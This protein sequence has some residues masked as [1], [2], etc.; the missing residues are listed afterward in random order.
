MTRVKGSKLPPGALDG[1]RVIDMTS[2]LFGPYCTQ[3]LGDMG[4]DVIKVEGLVGDSTRKTGPSRNPGMASVFLGNNRN[5]RSIAVDAKT[6]EGRDVIL[7]LMRE[8]HVFVTNVRPL[9]V[10]RLGLG[11]N[12]AC[13]ENPRLVYCNAVGYSQAGVYA[14]LPAFDDTIQAMCGTAA[15]QAELTGEP[16]YVGSAIADKVSGLMLA[17]AIV[18]AVRHAERTGEGQEVEVPMFE[19]MVS[20]N[21]VEHLYGSTFEP[22]MGEARYPRIISRFRRPYKTLDGYIAVIPYNDAHWKKFFAL[23]G[24]PEL[25]REPR[26]ATMG[27]RTSN[28]DALYEMLAGHIATRTSADWLERLQSADIPAAPVRSL[29]ELVAN[30]Q[31]LKETGFFRHVEHPTEG[32]ILHTA[33]PVRMGAS[34]L[35]LRRHAPKLGE[36][37]A[38]ILRELG[39]SERDIEHLRSIGA[40]A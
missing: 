1:I 37:S 16:Q 24:Q 25:M 30:D 33:S 21:L 39:K 5:K 14:A 19:A 9:A 10:D 29:P 20:F 15:L 32:P 17:L 18:A 3:W 27:D 36:H 8:A 6:A 28:V 40:I 11:Y 22:P 13:E 12:N 34:P 38:E 35:G 7:A 31:H 23:V 26:F 2:V 4:A